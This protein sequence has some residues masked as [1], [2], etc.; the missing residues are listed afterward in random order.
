M[1][2]MDTAKS[3]EKMY[4]IKKFRPFSIVF[5]DTLSMSAEWILEFPE[6][7]KQLKNTF[8]EVFSTNT[9][10][11]IPRVRKLSQE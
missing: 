1:W 6:T 7:Q 5:S 10:K 2:T 11:I 3:G 9:E 4:V 8:P